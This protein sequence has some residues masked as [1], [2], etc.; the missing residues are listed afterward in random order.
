MSRVFDRLGL[1]IVAPAELSA[2]R[3]AGIG[4]YGIRDLFL[5]AAPDAAVAAARTRAR[6]AG[7]YLHGWL[8]VDGRGA[9]EYAE[10]A[11]AWLGTEA[12]GL[13]LN[14]E[15]GSDDRLAGYVEYV[16]RTL[17]AHYPARPL[18][19]N[20]APWKGRYLPAAALARWN[21]HVA[22]Q[23][24]AGDMSPYAPL[25]VY[26]DLLEGGIPASRAQLCYGAAGPVCTGGRRGATLPL[27]RLPRDGV[28]FHE[29]LLADLGV[30]P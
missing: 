30:I 12:G 13:E 26:R 7:C 15:L 4:A 14:I 22:A 28:V 8:A 10:A 21:V 11:L 3:L 6:A 29:R 25:D 1:W 17:R 9:E 18:R 19:L 20:V 27:A 5:P 16:V 24:Y 2:E 23:T